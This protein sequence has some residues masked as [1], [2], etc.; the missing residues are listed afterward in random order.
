MAQQHAHSATETRRRERYDRLAPVMRLDS[1]FER[2]GLVGLGHR[3]RCS[4]S[5]GFHGHRER[6][7]DR[8]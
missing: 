8:Y 7:G 3:Q 4:L 1:A 6:V 2:D 5:L